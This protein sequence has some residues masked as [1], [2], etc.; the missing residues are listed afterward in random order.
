[1]GSITGAIWA[2]MLVGFIDAFG[3]V[4]FGYFTQIILL[5]LVIGV[6]V[7]KPTGLFSG[8]VFEIFTRDE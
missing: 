4:F 1:M 5:V 2:G 8:V 3:N 6:I 7:F